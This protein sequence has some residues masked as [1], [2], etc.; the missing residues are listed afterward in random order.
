[1]SYKNRFE[2]ARTLIINGIDCNEIVQ[3][4]SSIGTLR[5]KTLHVILKHTFEPD[6]SK[7]EIKVGNFHADIVNESGI[8]EIH[9]RNFSTLR[10]K[11]TFFLDEYI[12]TIVYPIAQ[13]K[14]LVWLDPETGE[15]TNKRKSPKT[16]R[17]YEAL[18]ELSRI[19]PML[20]HPNLRIG[21]VLMDIIE[22]RNLN[23]WSTDKKKGSSR[24]DCIPEKL[25]EV[26][27]IV[28][29]KDYQKFIP[30]D[31]PEVFTAKDFKKASG[32]SPHKTQFAVSVL[33]HVGAIVQK[34]KDGRAFLYFA[35]HKN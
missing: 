10:K 15:A 16:G 11:L 1:M 18:D 32:L 34:G 26:I 25:N 5:E 33:K 24:Y 13:T 7:H 4:K 19:K 21:I 17:I 23:G 31:L 28:E 3:A 27:D 14:W 6:E 2:N 9:T 8:I 35:A 29:L 30:S 20:T 22:Y 12:V